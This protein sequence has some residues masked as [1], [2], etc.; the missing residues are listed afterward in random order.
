[1]QSYKDQ[2]ILINRKSA[3]LEAGIMTIANVYY[4]KTRFSVPVI[5]A[6]FTA[7]LVLKMLLMIFVYLV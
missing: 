3:D 1:M 7:Q 4:V 5:F 6:F 2:M